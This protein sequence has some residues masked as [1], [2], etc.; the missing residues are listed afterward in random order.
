MGDL[1]L[2]M[3]SIVFD[4]FGIEISLNDLAGT[5][6]QFVQFSVFTE[7]ANS[8]GGIQIASIYTGVVAATQTIACMIL[9]AMLLVDMIKQSI[10]Y[11]RFTLEKVI[12]TLVKFCLYLWL[13]ENGT[14]IILKIFEIGDGLLKNV[15]ENLTKSLPE[16]ASIGETCKEMIDNAD[17]GMGLKWI[18]S[19]L[20]FIIFFVAY[21][22][23]LG[24]FVGALAQVVM[25]TFKI[26]GF[27]AILPIGIAMSIA[28]NGGSQMRRLINSSVAIIVEGFLMIIF[29]YL[30]QIGL[31][32]ISTSASAGENSLGLLIGIVVINTLLSTS[33]SQSAG[34]ADKWIG[35]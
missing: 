15:G 26:I 31:T 22:S 25:R 24:T 9:F 16:M 2:K 1:A 20:M 33:L 28:D 10:D 14:D 11:E 7:E 23:M 6:T 27:I 29:V 34:F 18:S 3:M 30:Y 4:L 19:M 13:I 35:A 17:F 32:I 21:I 12:F 8:A 5:I